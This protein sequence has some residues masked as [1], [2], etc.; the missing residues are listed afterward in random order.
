MFLR[1]VGAGAAAFENVGVETVVVEHGNLRS[2]SCRRRVD[3]VAVGLTKLLL[4]FLEQF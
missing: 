3:P 4:V 2:V 1:A